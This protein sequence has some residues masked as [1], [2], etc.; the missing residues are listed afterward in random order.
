[1]SAWSDEQVWEIGWAVLPSFQGRGIAS[2]AT[3]QVV[4][5]ARAGHH[6]RPVQRLALRPLPPTVR[7]RFATVS[8]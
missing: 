1:M 3:A 2:S 5:L 7:Q 4:D 8:S 6:R